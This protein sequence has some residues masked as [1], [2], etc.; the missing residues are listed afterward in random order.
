MKRTPHYILILIWIFHSINA[1]TPYGWES[2]YQP[3]RATYGASK[4]DHIHVQIVPQWQHDT[5]CLHIIA[6]TSLLAQD[7]Y[8]T[9]KL[10]KEGFE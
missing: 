4:P 7:L 9:Y 8:G 10:L 6:K 1:D 3:H 2:L 5:S